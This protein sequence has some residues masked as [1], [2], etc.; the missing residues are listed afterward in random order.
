MSTQQ[1]IKYFLIGLAIISFF[2]SGTI[3]EV[4][5]A[6][7]FTISQ[8]LSLANNK[9]TNTSCKYENGEVIIFYN[10]NKNK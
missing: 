7:N 2:V 3:I 8:C 10:E 6:R 9:E 4:S 5:K 1:K